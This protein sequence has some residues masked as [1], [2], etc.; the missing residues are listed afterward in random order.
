[1]KDKWAIEGGHGGSGL[2]NLGGTIRKGELSGGI[3][4]AVKINI[5]GSKYMSRSNGGY[6]WPAIKADGYYNKD[7]D[8]GAYGGSVKACRMGALL[9]FRN[10]RKPSDLSLR[11]REGKNL[12]WAIYYHGS[13]IADDT[14]A[15]AYGICVEKGSYTPTSDAFKADVNAIMKA[16]FVVNNNNGSGAGGTGNF[17]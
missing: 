14:Y 13:Y 9:T 2:S 17:R 1:M 8:P 3:G 6:R 16:L 5:Q 15:N 12:F 11:T 7:G 10:D 4:H